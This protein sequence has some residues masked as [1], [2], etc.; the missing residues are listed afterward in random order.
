VEVGRLGESPGEAGPGEPAPAPRAPGRI[1]LP[2]VGGLSV[3]PGEPITIER[4]D[5]G[6]SLAEGTAGV[7]V[8]GPF[9]G[10]LP[11]AAPARGTNGTFWSLPD[12]D[13]GRLQPFLEDVRADRLLFFAPSGDI[14]RVRESLGTWTGSTTDAADGRGVGPVATADLG[15]LVL[16]EVWLGRQIIEAGWW[17]LVEAGIAATEGSR[18]TVTGDPERA[19]HVRE[20]LASAPA[21]FASDDSEAEFLALGPAAAR[22]FDDLRRDLQVI[23]WQ[24]APD[25]VVL[26]PGTVSFSRFRGALAVYY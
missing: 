3:P 18:I 2:E 22:L 12:L 8:S 23:L 1:V 25:G 15:A 21:R 16:L 17:G 11:G 7:F 13:V 5:S 24:R 20:W 9:P 26:P 14:P 4:L 19:A 10:E 6:V